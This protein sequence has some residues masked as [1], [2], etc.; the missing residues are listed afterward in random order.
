MSH[1]YFSKNI[2]ADTILC[3]APITQKLASQA[4][5]PLHDVG[6]YFLFERAKDR[7]SNSIKI[8]AQVSTDEGAM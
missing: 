4:D 6:G 1:Y 3:L 5:S 2:D 8:I 7:E